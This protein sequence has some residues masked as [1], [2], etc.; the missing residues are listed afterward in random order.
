MRNVTQKTFL[1]FA[2]FKF[3]LIKTTPIALQKI[4][5]RMSDS[6]IVLNEDMQITDF[7]KTFLD[8]FSV[9]SSE[10]RNIN[11]VDLLKKYNA[12]DIDIRP[13]RDANGLIL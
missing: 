7:N 8:T 5:D 11:I 10:I 2:I 13:V 3:G 1:N 9:T 4:V 12:F 6:Y